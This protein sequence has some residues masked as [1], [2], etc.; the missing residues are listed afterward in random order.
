[1]TQTYT[2]PVCGFPGLYEAAY[3]KAGASSFEICPC[4]GIEFG[5]EDA[6]RSHEELRQKWIAEGMKW[7]FG[8][9]P[10]NWNP[11]TQLVKAGFE[12]PR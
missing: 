3:D 11:I 2:C 12:P 9:V 10:S 6:R 5:Y 7:H 4:C 1:M 8:S